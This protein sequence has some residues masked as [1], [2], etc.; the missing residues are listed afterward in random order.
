[1]EEAANERESLVT[2]VKE[3]NDEVVRKLAEKNQIAA[4]AMAHLGC[5]ERRAE[6]FVATCGTYLEWTGVELLFKGLSGKTNAINDPQ[7]KNFFEREYSF[8]LPPKWAVQDVGQ[9]DPAILAQAVAGSITAKGAVCR[10]L[11]N[12][13]AATEKLI[14]AER[15]KTAS[16]DDKEFEEFKRWKASR[17]NGNGSCHEKNPWSAEGN[18]DA[19]GRYTDAAIARQMSLV[20]ATGPEKAAQVAASVSAK[21]G[22]IYAP[23]FK[24]VH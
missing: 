7:A 4:Y 19:R 14:A 9:V 6:A 8:I 17:S 3:H 2:S 12:D 13:V 21:L 11:N 10:A 16:G 1:M 20:R 15:A 5:D 22:Q 24:G 18:T 23:G